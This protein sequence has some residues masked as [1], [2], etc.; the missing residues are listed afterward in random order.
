MNDAEREQFVLDAIPKN[1]N[2]LPLV[3]ENVAPYVPSIQT[4]AEYKI[5]FSTFSSL[6]DILAVIR[7]I[8]TPKNE[9]E[10][11]E[12]FSD[13]LEWSTSETDKL[14]ALVLERCSDG[15]KM[16]FLQ[17][18]VASKIPNIIH[19]CA[20]V[21]V[22][23][24][25]LIDK[26][27]KAVFSGKCGVNE[28]VRAKFVQCIQVQDD[29]CSLKILEQLYPNELPEFVEKYLLEH[30]SQIRN[31]STNL[32]RIFANDKQRFYA[33]GK[34]IFDMGQDP[35]YVIQCFTKH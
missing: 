12:F 6:F 30:T 9:Q 4:I 28:R 31:C 5:R 8:I 16:E 33:F 20:Q 3:L 13:N 26:Y 25:E 35:G 22:N 29:I 1:Y 18:C 27:D 23:N 24:D 32:Q 14:V 11:F 19:A 34:K 21:I 15:M 2:Q 17:Q 7:L 10:L